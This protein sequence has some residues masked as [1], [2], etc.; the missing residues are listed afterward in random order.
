MKG[1]PIKYL[2]LITWIGL[3]L[4]YAPY[5]CYSFIS[6]N[7]IRNDLS[8]MAHSLHF[9]WTCK[10]H[11]HLIHTHKGFSS[12]FLMIIPLH[13]LSY[14]V[15]FYTFMIIYVQSQISFYY[16]VFRTKFLHSLDTSMIMYISLYYLNI[17]PFLSIFYFIYRQIHPS[18]FH[19]YIVF[20]AVSKLCYHNP[21]IL[22]FIIPAFFSIK[23][24]NQFNQ[25]IWHICSGVIFGY[26]LNVNHS[27]YN[28]SS[29]II[30]FVSTS[31]SAIVS[32]LFI[33]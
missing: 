1:Y 20:I 2:F 25:Y 16:R 33:M 31:F 10:I 9:H 15:S 30:P 29:N 26:C 22:S 19:Q 4:I 21:S 27:V 11:N 32:N 28:F 7:Y 18:I 8:I 24:D 5:L 12:M 13:I 14:K 3:R 23:Y 6:D 17:P